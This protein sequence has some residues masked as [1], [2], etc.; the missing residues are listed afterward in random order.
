MNPRRI[1]RLLIGT[2]VIAAL[3]ASVAIA[4]T[5]Q[6]YHQKF[7]VKSPGKSTG[8]AF[9][10]SAKDSSGGAPTPAKKVTLTFPSGTR[11]NSGALPKCT[12]APHC[13]PSSL[14]GT[15][16]ATVLLG[17]SSLPLSAN[18]YNRAGGLAI[19]ILNPVVVLKP[20]L[21]GLKLI[22]DIPVL[23]VGTTRA[24]LTKLSVTVRTVGRGAR[25]YTTTPRTCPAAKAWTFKALF[26]YE[27]GTSKSLTSK[28]PCTRS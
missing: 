9:S 12:N 27:D 6:T 25:A 24:I 18:V 21:V 1:P 20:R 23:K 28:S 8:M 16:K 2:V 17:T 19:V 4:A 11:I 14:L 10:A 26:N 22:L 7:S 15:G 5:I 13:P 3:T